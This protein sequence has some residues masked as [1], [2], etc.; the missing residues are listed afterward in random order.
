MRLHT[1]GALDLRTSDGRELR[2]V[3]AQPKRVALLAYLGLA[4]PRGFHQ[5]DTLIALFWPEHDAERARNSLSQS[6]HVL[7]QGLGAG[8]LVSRNGD[9]LS[10]DWGDFWCDAVAFEDALDGGRLGDAV[11]LYRGELLEGFHVA[12]APEFERWLEIERERLA[13]RYLAALQY[14]ADERA[15]A[16]DYFGAVTWWRRLAAREPYSSRV[17]LQLMRALAA[18]GDPAAA[19]KHARI[20]EALLRE[21]LDIAPDPE[22]VALVRQ[23]QSAPAEKHRLT[24][25]PSVDGEARQTLPPATAATGPVVPATTDV[26]RASVASLNGSSGHRRARRRRVAV[27]TTFFGVSVAVACAVA[28][29][30]GGLSASIPPIRSLAV[31]PLESLSRDPADQLF[32]DGMHDELIEEVGRYPEFGVRAR[33]SVLQYRATTK[34]RTEIS[35]DLQVDG[36]VEGTVLRDGGRVR[37][38]VELVHGPSNRRIWGQSYTRDLRDVLE[39]QREV[40]KAIARELRVAANPVTRA[41]HPASGPP[42]S[43]PD[44]LHLRD[45]YF[46]GRYAEVSRNLL[47]MQ[48]AIGYY[49]QAIE[50]DSSFG[51]GYAGLS[52]AYALKAH[53]NFAPKRAMLDSARIM[54]DRAVKL[55]STLPEARTARALSLGNTG[56]FDAAEREFRRAIELGPSNPEAP[57]WYGMLLVGLGRGAEGLAQAERALQLDP[58]GP[59][60]ALATKRD[61]LYLLTGERAHLKLPVKERQPILKL[62]PG[63]PWARGRDATEFAEEGRCDDAR[64]QILRARQLVPDSNLVML[65][66]VG[67]VYWSCGDSAGARTVLARMKRHSDARE[68]GLRVAHLYTQFGEKDSAFV[69]LGRHRWLISELAML[70]GDRF[71]DPLRSDRRFPELLKRLGIR[72]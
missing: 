67:R 46:H 18:A 37:M 54:A 58:L 26:A 21:E 11:D 28:F 65:G 31:L 60:A 5:R 10:L 51:L 70:S 30:R 35:K 55:D 49:R 71:L 16:G 9:A 14:L 19:V 22:V 56:Q 48:T 45:L 6:V 17:T 34:P 41:R 52:E 38:N 4:K 53:Y 40:A 8:T 47:G 13:R 62:E 50:K 32:A 2:T 43:V 61:A 66:F 29:M 33:A 27:S 63:E 44:E 72:N 69:W 12:G 25:Q 7:R 68:H 42:D 24:R 20:H 3:L 59:R 23:L 15:A 57:Y 1:L 39:L 36:I 64:S